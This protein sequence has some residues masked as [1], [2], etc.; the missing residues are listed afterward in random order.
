M[1]VIVKKPTQQQ[2]DLFKN[3]PSWE[4]SAY[5]GQWKRFAADEFFLAAEGNAVLHCEGGL[6]VPCQ[7]GDFVLI[8]KGT[9]L[10]WEV[11]VHFKKHF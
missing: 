4:A 7:K 3:R 8:Q 11:P 6:D 5:T 9:N 2:I 10:Y 1:A